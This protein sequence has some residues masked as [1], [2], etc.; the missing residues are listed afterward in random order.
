MW[1]CL[2]RCGGNATSI[3]ENLSQIQQYRH[4]FSSILFERFNLGP[5]ST[6]ILNNLT[7]VGPSLQAIG[8]ETYPMISSYPYPPQFL[9]WMRELFAN[10]MPFIE[11]AVETAVANNYTGFNIDWEPTDPG[12][13]EDAADYAN[14]LSTFGDALHSKSKKLSVDVATWNTIWNLTLLS[15]S[16]ADNL[17]DMG[18]YTG[19]LE[20]FR[21]QLK[22]ATQQIGLK[23]LAAGL[24]TLDTQT[25]QPFTDKDLSERFDMLEKNQVQEIAIWDAPLQ[26]NW[27]GHLRHFKHGVSY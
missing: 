11:L 8:L 13:Q 14:F 9:D 5:N 12:T 21:K 10:P 2:E 7:N 20:S 3:E 24:M 19:G 22:I 18:T 26:D 23:K 4:L 16:G 25:N 15:A 17:M 6:L 27:W 1:M